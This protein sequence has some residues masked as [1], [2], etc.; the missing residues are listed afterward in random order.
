MLLD[1]YSWYARTHPGQ[2]V[3]SATSAHAIPLSDLLACAKAQGTELRPADILF[4]RTGFT[5]WYETA[6][7]EE[8]AKGVRGQE[9]SIGVQN[10][11]EVR[12]W[13]WDSHFA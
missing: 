6:S 7:I 9:G 1:W 5:A 3:P 8:R 2:S 11:E 13:L 4:V 10:S 12:R